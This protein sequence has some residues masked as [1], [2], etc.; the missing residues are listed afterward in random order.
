MKIRVRWSRSDAAGPG[1]ASPLGREFAALL[2]GAGVLRLRPYSTFLLAFATVVFGI[3]VPWKRALDFY[4]PLL[5]FT[6]SVATVFLAGPAVTDLVGSEWDSSRTVHSRVFACA[7][8][9]SGLFG[10]MMTVGT[11]TVNVAIRPGIAWPPVR[12]LGAAFALNAAA[13][14]CMASIAALLTVVLTPTAAKLLVRGG[15]IV[16]LATLLVGPRLLSPD[17]QAQL[18]SNLTP[19]SLI[20]WAY[21]GAGVLVLVA[22]GPISALRGAHR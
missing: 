12:P 15:M 10:W 5:I 20:F 22:A 11:A 21:V 13:A 2:R 16:A 14:L 18:A 17:A 6:Y 1:A 3:A 7:L 8:F 9:S 4:D 19:G